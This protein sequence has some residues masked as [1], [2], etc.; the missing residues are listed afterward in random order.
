MSEKKA[1][2]VIGYEHDPPKIPIQPLI[3]SFEMLAE[4]I[5]KVKLGPRE[6]ENRKNLVHPVHQQLTVYAW[7]VLGRL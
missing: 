6:I 2:V 3:E 7:E 5:M 1:V 4:K